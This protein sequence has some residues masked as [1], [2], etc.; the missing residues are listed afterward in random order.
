DTGAHGHAMGF[1]YNAR[2]R[3]QELLL[4]ADGSV[5][6]IRRAETMNDYFATLDFTPDRLRF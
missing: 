1:N 4:R 3:P 6:L 5:E 2:L